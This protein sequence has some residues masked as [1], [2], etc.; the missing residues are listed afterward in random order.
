MHTTTVPASPI[1]APLT[2]AHAYA[3]AA[4]ILSGVL[5]LTASAKLQ[6][7]LWPLPMTMPSGRQPI[8]SASRS[9]R[10]VGSE[11]G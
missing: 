5:L 6:V 11:S 8:N 2:S 7:P 4:L 9:S 10:S 1:A 3:P